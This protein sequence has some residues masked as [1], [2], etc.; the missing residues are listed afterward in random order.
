MI[1]NLHVS[2]DKGQLL[3]SVSLGAMSK[4]G[5]IEGLKLNEIGFALRQK[6]ENPVDKVRLQSS[7]TKEP[8]VHFCHQSCLSEC[9][10]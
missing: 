4:T 5:S 2:A 3:S 7:K 10:F 1:V 8:S 6:D 9:L